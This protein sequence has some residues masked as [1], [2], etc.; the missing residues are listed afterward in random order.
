MHLG[1]SGCELSRD[2]RVGPIGAADWG[3]G[4]FGLGSFAA[5][6]LG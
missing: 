1:C 6:G 5:D 3:C 2:V 4:L